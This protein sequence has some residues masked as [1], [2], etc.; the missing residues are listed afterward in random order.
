MGNKETISLLQLFILLLIFEMGSATVVGIGGEAK[1]NVW[2]A[3]LIAGLIG[4]GYILLLHFMLGRKVGINLFGLIEFCLGKWVG[5]AISLLYI[6][7]FVYLSSRVLRDFGELI[8]STI[9]IY[10]PIEIISITIMLTIIYMLYAGI[11]VM[12]RTSEIFFPYVFS[13]T[14]LV[15]LFILLSGEIHVENLRPFLEDG[16]R[17]VLKAVFPGLLTFP[18]GELIAFATVLPLVTKFKKAKG[19]AIGGI[20][21]S[22]LVLV[23]SAI[24]QVMTLG[25]EMKRRANFPLLSAAREISLLDFIE[26]VDIAV[27]FVVM[28]GIM[29]KIG[30]FFFGAVK[31]LEHI[32]KREYRSFLFPIGSLICLSSIIITDSFAE[33]IE[34]GLR[35]VPYFIHIPFQFALPFLLLVIVLIRTRKKNRKRGEMEWGG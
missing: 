22:T 24:I 25:Q 7:Y 18:F 17:P 31:G 26:R 9:F 2:L 8:V 13:F 34:E 21:L 10:T 29:V 28:F 30:I 32:S 16:I 14:F 20:V 23:Y 35:I 27:V 5:R 3:I 19:F 1:Q 12:A 6:L 4:V 15:G 11:E 33:H